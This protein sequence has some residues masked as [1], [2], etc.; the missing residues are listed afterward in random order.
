MIFVIQ[1]F[2]VDRIQIVLEFGLIT[3]GPVQHG[4]ST[5]VNTKTGTQANSQKSHFSRAHTKTFFQK[6]NNFS[7]TSLY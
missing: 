3:E 4:G 1:S 6:T 5:N 7:S 2:N